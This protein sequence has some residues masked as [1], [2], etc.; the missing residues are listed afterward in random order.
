MSHQ[1]IDNHGQQ[2]LGQ[3]ELLKRFP[4]LSVKPATGTSLFI[5]FKIYA[6]SPT[7]KELAW[8]PNSAGD[9]LD[10]NSSELIFRW[11]CNWTVCTVGIENTTGSER[12]LRSSHFSKFIRTTEIYS[13]SPRCWKGKKGLNR[14]RFL[15]DASSFFSSL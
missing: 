14:T 1:Y 2:Q 8:L 13:F 9:V 11:E 10:S 3:L 5:Y 12:F 4:S 7:T 15:F 6:F